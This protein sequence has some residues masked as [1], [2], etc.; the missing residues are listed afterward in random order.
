M[1]DSTNNNPST[2]IFDEPLTNIEIEEGTTKS[3]ILPSVSDGDKD[4]TWT[5]CALGKVS[6][7]GG[8]ANSSMVL[9]LAPKLANTGNYTVT[10]T[11]TDEG[12]PAKS[13]S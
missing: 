1:I 12:N 3:F 2:P 10:C 8:Y 13:S 6:N 7:F 4:K 5:D 11:V 9:N